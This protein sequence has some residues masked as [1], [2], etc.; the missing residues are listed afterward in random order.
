MRRYGKY[1]MT[2]LFLL[3]QIT[4]ICPETVR[5]EEDASGFQYEI[6][7]NEIIIKDYLGNAARIEIPDEIDGMPV[8]LIAD[9]AFYG[10]KA[11]EVV[12]GANV[13]VIEAGAF[14]F[15]DNLTVLRFKDSKK[16]LKIRSWAFY[17]CTNLSNLEF[18]NRP[19]ELGNDCFGRIGVKELTITSNITTEAGSWDHFTGAVALKKLTYDSPV[20]GR[21]MFYAC[22]ALEQVILTDTVTEIRDRAFQACES[23]QQIEMG[24]SVESLGERALSGNSNLETIVLPDSLK[25][26]GKACFSECDKLTEL[27]IPKNVATIDEDAFKTCPMLQRFVVAD[28]NQTYSA[29]E[30]ILCNK[31]QTRAIVAPKRIAG[32]LVLPEGM[33]VIEADCFYNC[34]LLEEVTLPDTLLAIYARAFESCTALKK[35]EI[36]DS[37]MGGLV[38]VF[39]G[40]SSLETAKIGNGVT[41]LS[42]TFFRCES[43][44]TVTM[45]DSVTTLGSSVFCH[46]SSLTDIT[47]SKNI[48]EIS[49]WA[50][51]G[52]S[53]LKRLQIP[54][55]IKTVGFRALQYCT[56]LEELT[57]SD[58]LQ[59][60]SRIWYAMADNEN[61]Q[62][63]Y[64]QGEY[65]SISDNV[66]FNM[67]PDFVVFYK[68][69]Y[70]EWS[71]Y[72][73]YP[74]V[75]VTKEMEGLKDALGALNRKKVMLADKARLEQYSAVYNGLDEQQ[76]KFYLKEELEALKSCLKKIEVL[77]L[78]KTIE[79]L[80]EADK[81]Q[82]EDKTAIR[83]VNTAY[84]QLTDEY[85][86]YITT[87]QR[88][89]LGRLV[90]QLE[91][92]LKLQKI[93]LESAD[94]SNNRLRMTVGEKKTITIRFM[95][96]YAEY[97][98]LR[99]ISDQ[100][101]KIASVA[102]S[103]DHK[104]ITLTGIAA[105]AAVITTESQD[106]TNVL[107]VKVCLQTPKNVKVRQ[108]Y[109][110]SAEVTWSRVSGA[111]TYEIY[112]KEG[113]GEEKLVAAQTSAVYV[114]SGLTDGVDYT[115]RVTACVTKDGERYDSDKSTAV[116]LK[117]SGETGGSSVVE[118]PAKNGTIKLNVSTLPLQKGKSTTCVV[119]KKVTPAGNRIQSAVSSNSKV[120]AVK[121]SAGKLKITGKKAGTAYITV[122]GSEGGTAKVKVKV[123]NKKV[124]TKSLSLSS[125][126][127][128]LKRGKKYTLKVVRN[129][130]T[131]TD[132][133]SFRSSNKKIVSVNAK[134]VVTA[135]KKGTVKIT[136]K[137][138]SGKKTVC[139]IRVK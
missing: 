60:V 76:Q 52:C 136:V 119:L 123:Q 13:G 38:S 113:N 138:A 107:N 24:K 34:T 75:P 97:S 128:V 4:W 112:R 21:S 92:L 26:I 98:G 42:S 121:L 71:Q 84:N 37:V 36:P 16:E 48:T 9:K 41:S 55:G 86:S 72:T 27:N 130:L 108:L 67:S 95:P 69:A 101:D 2:V 99:S 50:F 90:K 57:F 23:L 15:M 12:I 116:S 89:K 125:K 30:G 88:V 79:A 14:E 131:A 19:I 137:A 104:T 105:G 5:A 35:I 85:K 62:Y 32:K 7:N 63:V 22:P 47:L 66:F 68:E 28:E 70:P 39:H 45:T 78:G 96:S 11:G 115:Y 129:P 118:E 58:R 114:D 132:K 91:K 83:T 25:S 134:G 6:S 29:Y 111:K 73:K 133:L 43:L 124:A 82:P 122:T 126:K 49:D 117:M 61:L 54:E 65:V 94:I 127:L 17:G 100:Q 46:C 135:K 106:V 93:G 87:K 109:D 59:E 53:S 103:E 20:V 18:G 139:T 77:E 80:P 33:R 81:I 74:V 120:A 31:E 64:F 51:Y 8:T 3:L 1:I 110:R 10:A 56:S 40:C 44:K 102:L